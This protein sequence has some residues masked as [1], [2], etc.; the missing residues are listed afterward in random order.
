M[1]LSVSHA[2]LSM[3]LSPMSVCEIYG[4]NGVFLSLYDKFDTID[5]ICGHLM[6]LMTP[7]VLKTV[8]TLLEINKKG[9]ILCDRTGWYSL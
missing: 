6:P 1:L 9:K 8:Q 2:V 4:V 7:I 3:F 5:V